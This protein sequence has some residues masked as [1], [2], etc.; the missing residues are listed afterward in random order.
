MPWHALFWFCVTIFCVLFFMLCVLGARSTGLPM[1]GKMCRSLFDKPGHLRMTALPLSWGD[2]PR[3]I[4]NAPPRC[5]SDNLF[6]RGESAASC[7]FSPLPTVFSRALFSTPSPLLWGTNRRDTFPRFPAQD[8]FSTVLCSILGMCSAASY[9]P[10]GW[11]RRKVGDWGRKPRR[12]RGIS[13]A[14]RPPSLGLSPQDKSK[15]HKRAPARRL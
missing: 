1:L 2:N 6:G 13:M 10:G 5:A 4:L 8:L 14:M 7:L 15:A 9:P 3:G 11:G 12:G